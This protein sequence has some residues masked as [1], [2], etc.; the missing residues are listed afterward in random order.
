MQQAIDHVAPKEP[1]SKKVQ[2]GPTSQVCSICKVRG[3]TKL[4]CKEAKRTAGL[5]SGASASCSTAD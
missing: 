3:H 1:S 4:R 2:S 5:V